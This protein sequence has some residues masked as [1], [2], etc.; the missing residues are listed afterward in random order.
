M[1]KALKEF[2]EE[3][4]DVILDGELYNHDLRDDFNTITSVVRK[5][6]P[7]Q[8][9]IDKAQSLVQYHVYDIIDSDMVESTFD[10]RSQKVAQ[11]VNSLNSE[12]ISL[13]ETTVVESKEELDNLYGAYLEDGFEGQMVRAS[14]NMT[15]RTRDQSHLREKNF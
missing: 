15:M 3:N 2:F 13:V 11:V 14:Q 4:P 12:C 8:A 7:T 10:N 9:D 5:T 1:F 6:K